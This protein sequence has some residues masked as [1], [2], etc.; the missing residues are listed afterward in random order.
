MVGGTASGEDRWAMLGA[1]GAAEGRYQR[2]CGND[3]YAV[4]SKEGRA[5]GGDACSGTL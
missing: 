1:G 4:I 2:S 5:I 3:D